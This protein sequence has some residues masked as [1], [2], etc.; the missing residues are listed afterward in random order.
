MKDGVS[1]VIER[2]EFAH[3]PEH[4]GADD[5]IVDCSAHE[6]ELHETD[7]PSELIVRRCVVAQDGHGVGDLDD[8][9]AESEELEEGEC[10][11]DGGIASEEAPNAE[12]EVDLAGRGHEHGELEGASESSNHVRT[13]SVAKNDA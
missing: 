13:I 7:E 10:S 3:W 4:A 6:M 11:S 5:K 2:L 8:A 1:R 9:D 12:S